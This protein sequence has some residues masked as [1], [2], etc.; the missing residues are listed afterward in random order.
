[1]VAYTVKLT[2]EPGAVTQTDIDELRAAGFDDL[3]ILDV[4]SQCAHLNYANRVV[5][6]LGIRTIADPD[7]PAHHTI[8]ALATSQPG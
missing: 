7:F 5:L 6:G 2:R 3:D 4:N 8:P 1:M